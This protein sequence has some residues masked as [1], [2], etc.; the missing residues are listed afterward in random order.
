MPGGTLNLTLI[1][2]SP[3]AATLGPHMRAWLEENLLLNLERQFRCM[4]PSKLF[5]LWLHDASL[6]GEGSTI[7]TVKFQA[8]PDKSQVV[9]GAD[10]QAI[11]ERET[12]LE[13]RSLVGRMLWM[14]VWGAFIAAE[15]WWWEDTECVQECIRLGTYWEYNLIE[16]V[17]EP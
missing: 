8:V 9:E 2:P 4:N 3:V 7:T 10:E 13:L 14:E 15:Q 1:D 12:R 5:P 6:R 11:A 17:K 16:A